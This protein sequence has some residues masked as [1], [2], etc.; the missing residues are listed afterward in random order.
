MKKVCAWCGK[1][2]GELASD[3]YPQDIISHGLC[4]DC[5]TGLFAQMGMPLG[6]YLD[7]LGAPVVVV[8]AT[9]T[10]STA[11]KQAREL[12]QKGLPDIEGYK[13]GDVFECVHAQEPGGCGETIHCSGCTIR[14]AVMDTLE[15]SQSHLKVPAYLN[16]E[17]ADGVAKIR[18]LISTEKVGTVVLLRM[19]AVEDQMLW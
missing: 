17:G 1:D 12:L 11:N 10:I 3:L 8:D 18:F 9:G 13:G 16:R 7:G 14:R 4:K 5:E 19:D 2:M 6:D 15:T